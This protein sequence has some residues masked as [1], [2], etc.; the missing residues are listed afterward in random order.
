VV[1]ATTIYFFLNHVLCKTR[2]TLGE[3]T[4]RTPSIFQGEKGGMREGEKKKGKEEREGC[5]APFF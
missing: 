3:P 4:R 2:R 1:E 5:R